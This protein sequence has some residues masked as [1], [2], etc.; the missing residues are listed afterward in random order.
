MND[1]SLLEFS[2]CPSSP[3]ERFCSREPSSAVRVATA[4]VVSLGLF[5]MGFLA[6]VAFTALFSSFVAYFWLR[7]LVTIWNESSLVVFAFME[8]ELCCLL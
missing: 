5:D 6:E 7:R 1:G 2:P 3:D 4:S 8:L